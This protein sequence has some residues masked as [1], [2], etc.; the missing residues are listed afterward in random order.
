MRCAW[1]PRRPRWSLV[2]RVADCVPVLLADPERGVVGAVHAGRPGLVAGVVPAAV[3]VMRE[4]GAERAGRVGRPAVCGALLRGAREMRA[5]VAPLVPRGLGETSWG[6]PALD[7][8]AGVR[9]QLAAARRRGRR[10]RR[11]A[12]SRRRTSTPTAATVPAPAVGRPDLGAPVSDAR[13][14]DEIAART[15]RP[16]AARID[17]ACAAAGRDAGRGDAG[18]G[19]QVLPRRPTYAC[20]PSSAC[21]TWGRTVTR[22]RSRS[23]GV[24][25]PRP[26]LALHRGAAEQQGGRRRGVRATSCSRSTGPGCCAALTAAPTS[27][28]G[29]RRAWSR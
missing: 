17:D 21:A 23:R 20:S 25:R 11:A 18:R 5:E 13:R 12:P 9:A 4:L 24:R 28:T 10:R 29:P 15:S 3:A 19:D 8:G 6:T 27:A 2:V 14:R 22:R 26:A 7:L 16:C 1:S